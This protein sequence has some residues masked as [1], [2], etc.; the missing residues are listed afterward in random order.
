MYEVTKENLYI[1]DLI[2]RANEGN[3]NAQL[4]VG[5]MYYQKQIPGLT[6]EEYGKETLR[7]LKPL[8]DK[9]NQIAICIIEVM[10][11]GKKIAKFEEIT[12]QNPKSSKLKKINVD[13]K[14]KGHE[15]N[16]KIQVNQKTNEEKA[17]EH[18]QSKS[19]KHEIKLHEQ[20]LD[21]K[22]KYCR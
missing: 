12:P 19:K 18:L 11:C 13:E 6:E 17:N 3:S 10:N 1:N 20:G 22:T 7:Y 21:K 4:R 9:K 14:D 5:I 16:S 15:G 8:A 2:S